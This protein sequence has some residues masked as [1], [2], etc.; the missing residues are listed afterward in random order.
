MQARL[1]GDKTREL[2]D[3]LYPQFIRHQKIAGRRIRIVG[4]WTDSLPGPKT[5]DSG[6]LSL[7]A[8]IAGYLPRF[9]FTQQSGLPYYD[10]NLFQFLLTV[11]GDQLLRPSQRRSL[12]R[13]ALTP[14]VPDQVLNRKTKSLGR[15]IPILSILDNAATLQ[16]ILPTTQIGQSIVDPLITQQYLDCLH[17]GKAGHSPL[18]LERILG[19]CYL[20]KDVWGIEHKHRRDANYVSQ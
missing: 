18:L 14:V 20:Y 4:Y 11:P 9:S 1:G 12:M 8:S 2:A 10:R 17:E 15:R 7:A 3:W 6:Y 5:A 19:A 16:S 13:R